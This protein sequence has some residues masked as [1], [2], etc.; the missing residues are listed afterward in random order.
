MIKAS[1][2][3]DYHINNEIFNLSNE[4]VNRDNCNY[5]SWLLKN[6]LK[7][8]NIDLSTFDINS[9]DSSSI[10]FY[11][12]YP[13]NQRIDVSK[14]NYLFMFESEVIKPKSWCS[15]NHSYFSRVFTWDDEL[16]DNDK[17]F[18]INYCHLFPKDKST[19]RSGLIDFENKKLCALIAG[20]KR[21]IHQNELYSERIKTI[22]WFEENALSDFDLYGSGW[23]QIVTSNRYVN[24]F[25]RKFK[26]LSLLCGVAYSSYQ[27]K[28]GSKFETLKNYK[29]SICYENAKEL[30]GYITE[31][32]FD[33]FFSG[34]IPVYWG[35]PNVSEHIPENC[36]IDRRLFNSN[37]ELYSYLKNMSEQEYKGYIDNIESFLFS[38][39][40]DQFKA[41]I[42]S[43]IV[44]KCLG[45]DKK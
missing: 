38:E 26:K 5:N 7:K 9:V 39:S 37:E 8:I 3:V 40:S 28:V 41:E 19:Y 29:F 31:K 34:C 33:S 32:I 15:K 44:I 36:Y 25:L 43:K 12:D 21:V 18:K 14:T 30:P 20:N 27:G 22:R 2:V 10:V 11:F 42:F 16:V 45:Y 4:S 6:E 23:E 35:A 13:E 24:F 17:Y 1:L